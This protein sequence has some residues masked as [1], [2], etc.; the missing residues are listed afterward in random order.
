MR[1]SI[2]FLSRLRTLNV[3]TDSLTV[4][5]RS[6]FALEEHANTRLVHDKYPCSLDSDPRRLSIENRP[7]CAFCSDLA[8]CFSHTNS[9]GSLKLQNRT[10]WPSDLS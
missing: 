5:S 7:F 8:D 3:F 4:V 10:R 9:P 6:E 1:A 2:G